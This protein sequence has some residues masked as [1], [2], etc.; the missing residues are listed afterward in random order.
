MRSLQDPE[1]IT[2][3]L[4]VNAREIT[5]Q[6]PIPKSAM[7]PATPPRARSRLGVV[8][9]LVGT[10]LLM[11]GAADALARAGHK[12]PALPLFLCAISLLFGACAWR[13]TS[14]HAG[15]RERVLVSLALGL[16]LHG[17]RA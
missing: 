13:L 6:S 15:R 7:T 2:A 14:A 16:A 1:G 4:P 3:D 11:Q 17:G 5:R 9:A 10:G 12:S 8:L